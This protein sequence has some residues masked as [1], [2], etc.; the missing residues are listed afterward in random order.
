MGSA[1]CLTEANILPKLNENSCRDKGDK[2]Q[3]RNSRLKLVIL[4]CDLDL[5]SAWLIMGSAHRL[6]EENIY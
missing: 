3:T 1:H 6:T 4:N 5:E 2:D